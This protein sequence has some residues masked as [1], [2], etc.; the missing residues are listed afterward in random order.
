MIRKILIP[1]MAFV[2][3]VTM[4][5]LATAGKAEKPRAMAV[6][7]VK[8]EAIVKSVDY[9]NKT[10]TITRG[11]KTFT[12]NTKNARNL[13]QVLAGDKVVLE[14]IE[15]VALVVKKAGGPPA[16]DEVQTVA[17]APKGKMPGA[18]VADTV[19]L[20]AI[21]SNVDLKKRTVTVQGPAGEQKSYKVG[22]DLKYFKNIKK[23]DEV[24]LRVTDALAVKVVKKK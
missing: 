6:E 18:I 20:K 12:V 11:D 16:A 21:V 8:Y 23:G 17:L 4:V 22:K 14:Y 9:V 13:D 7:V 15:A 10:M 24:V 3:V 1:F 19:E 5:S 2:F